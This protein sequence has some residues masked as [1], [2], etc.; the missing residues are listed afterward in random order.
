MSFLHY[1]DEKRYFLIFFAGMLSFVALM[2]FVS[3]E[4]TYHAGDIAY[5]LFGCALLA[6]VYVTGG[7]FRW[8]SRGKMLQELVNNRWDELPAALPEPYNNEQRQYTELI[9][10]LYRNKLE[11]VGKLQDEKKDFHDFI[12][13][14]IHEVKLPITACTLLFRNA[15]GKSVEELVHI[16]EDELYKIDHY[17]EQALYYARIDSFARDYL[18]AEVSLN[19]IVRNSVRKYAKMFVAKRVHFSMWEKEEWVH[20]DAKWLGYIVD[21]IMSNALK[22]LGDGG[23]I[24][25]SFEADHEEKRLSIR[26]TG[27]GIKA[28]DL[29]RIFEKGFTGANGRRFA[30]STGLGL[31][32]ANRMAGKLGH[33]LS[34]Q[35]EE[36]SYTT[37]TIHFP[38]SNHLYEM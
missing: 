17:V 29:G 31:Y 33:R 22:Y 2:M 14:W 28:E 11:A 4:G 3:P 36:G 27:I 19:R 12:V 10:K 30:K 21:Q 34:V 26:D 7:Y 16:F 35:S 23:S 38:K 20:S 24:T 8:R 6:A 37:L 9:K 18:I 5:T 32:L 25:C 13:S 15:S 1:L